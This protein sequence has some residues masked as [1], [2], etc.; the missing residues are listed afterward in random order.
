MYVDGHGEAKLDG[1]ANFDLGEF[2]RQL[3]TKGFR[4]Q[5]LNLTIAP[6]VP[7]T[8]YRECLS[9]DTNPSY[10]PTHPSCELV[11]RNPTNGAVDPIV[12]RPDKPRLN[13]AVLI[14]MARCN[15]RF[16]AS[17]SSPEI[18]DDAS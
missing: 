3:N 6:Q 14:A 11:L 12:A 9:A 5:G 8:L 2:G 4:V 16:E 13:S 17:I 15:A 7:D 18:S 10:S 1:S